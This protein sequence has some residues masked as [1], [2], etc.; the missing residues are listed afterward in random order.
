MAGKKK[1]RK[2]NDSTKSQI[3]RA[4][5]APHLCQHSI[6]NADGFFCLSLSLSLVFV[7]V[8]AVISI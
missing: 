2:K 5:P 1:T 7:V 4:D 8:G 3:H 6:N